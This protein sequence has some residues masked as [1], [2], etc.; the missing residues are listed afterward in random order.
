MF[1]DLAAFLLNILSLGT[2]AFFSGIFASSLLVSANTGLWSFTLAPARKQKLMWLTVSMPW[3][4][5]IA[6]PVLLAL[7]LETIFP[8]LSDMMHWHHSNEFVINSWHIYLTILFILVFSFTFV[9]SCVLAARH[10]QTFTHFRTFSDSEGLLDV[11]EPNAFSAGLINPQTFITKGLATKLDA[12]ELK[13]VQLHELSH[14]KNRDSLKKLIFGFMSSF[15]PRSISK[16][17]QHEMAFSMELIAD[18]FVVSSGVSKFDIATTLLK[19]SK[20]ISTYERG[21]VEANIQCNF[22]GNEVKAR[23]ENLLTQQPAS[24]ITNFSLYGSLILISL[25]CLLS[26]DTFHHLVETFF[27]H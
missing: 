11:R 14:V 24:T 9:K 4:L 23:I 7:S 22:S 8:K 26:L 3:A 16:R 27:H 13:I 10:A 19:V 25:F 2:V 20:I 1:F 17:L 21:Q 12:S 5:A 15:F 6:S 18:S